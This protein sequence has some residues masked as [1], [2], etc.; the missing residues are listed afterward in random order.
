MI[1]YHFIIYSDPNSELLVNSS[2]MADISSYTA[3]LVRLNFN[4]KHKVMGSAVEISD[5][6]IVGDSLTTNTEWFKKLSLTLQKLRLAT[7]IINN[8]LSGF[9]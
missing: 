1:M 7:W 6:I 8:F 5:T 4:V 3:S 2:N 9:Q